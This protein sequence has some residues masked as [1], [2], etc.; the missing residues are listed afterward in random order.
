[1]G[2]RE[3]GPL[4]FRIWWVKRW[5]TGKSSYCPFSFLVTEGGVVGM[6]GKAFP[7]AFHVRISGRGDVWIGGRK[8]Y[9]Q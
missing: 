3:V 9:S 6:D 8:V 7:I 5:F 2:R 4:Y 1:M